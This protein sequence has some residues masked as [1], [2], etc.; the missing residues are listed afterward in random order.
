MCHCRF[1]DNRITAHTKNY[2][3]IVGYGL[4]CNR[5]YILNIIAFVIKNNKNYYAL[6]THFLLEQKLLLLNYKPVS[7]LL[8]R[9]LVKEL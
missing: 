2:E 9:K 4:L 5:L 7:F 8:K 6:S 3:L 1:C